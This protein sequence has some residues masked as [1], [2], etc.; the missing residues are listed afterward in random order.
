[1]TKTTT[2]INEERE[3]LEA[4]IWELTE[5][6]GSRETVDRIMA[7][8]DLFS[9]NKAKFLHAGGDGDQPQPIT[10]ASGQPTVTQVA[11]RD[12][13]RHMLLISERSLTDTITE[14][15]RAGERICKACFL[16]KP[17]TSFTKDKSRSDGLLS[18]CKQCVKEGKKIPK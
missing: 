8:V 3:A 5:W 16:P 7:A 1:M 6:R 14:S 13:E 18:R 17:Q 10:M 4:L 11:A 2:E 12:L 15:I 9:T